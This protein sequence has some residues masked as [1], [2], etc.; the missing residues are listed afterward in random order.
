MNIEQINRINAAIKRLALELRASRNK[1]AQYA[2]VASTK[3]GKK[4][5]RI[6]GPF[7][8]VM[9][10]DSPPRRWRLVN[11][12]FLDSSRSMGLSPVCDR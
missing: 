6:S 11:G 10:F 4:I 1:R 2:H 7:K 9:T 8:Q 5:V 3:C 12:G